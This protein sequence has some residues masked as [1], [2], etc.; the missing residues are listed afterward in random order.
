MLGNKSHH[1][2]WANL[3]RKVL[4]ELA[5]GNSCWK[6]SEVSKTHTAQRLQDIYIMVRES[7]SKTGK[8]KTKSYYKI[9]MYVQNLLKYLASAWYRYYKLL[10]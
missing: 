10:V 2:A 4:F 1:T 3:H 6:W 9:T 8:K 7:R 5:L